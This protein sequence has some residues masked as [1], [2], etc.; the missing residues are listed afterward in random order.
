MGR[1]K[2]GMFEVEKKQ[3]DWHDFFRFTH[4][5]QTQFRLRIQRKSN[6]PEMKGMSASRGEKSVQVSW[7]R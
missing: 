3:R 4:L 6:A 7:T 1:G 2:E 5:E